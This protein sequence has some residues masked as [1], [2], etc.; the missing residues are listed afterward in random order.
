MEKQGI[1]INGMEKPGFCFIKGMEK[2]G[3]FTN[4]MENL[5]VLQTA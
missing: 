3:I 2:P 4:G 1:F 5:G